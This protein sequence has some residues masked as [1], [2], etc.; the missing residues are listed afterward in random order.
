VHSTLA[1]A[2][3]RRDLIVATRRA[4]D[5]RDFALGAMGLEDAGQPELG[6]PAHS[7]FESVDWS[8]L[9]ASSLV[10]ACTM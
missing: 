6:L 3:S 8:A 2:N 4:Q 5:P 10:T 1:R 7:F 9:V